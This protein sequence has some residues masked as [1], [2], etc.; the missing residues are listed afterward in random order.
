MPNS[1]SPV[2]SSNVNTVQTAPRQN[3]INTDENP[4]IPLVVNKIKNMLLENSHAFLQV[5]PA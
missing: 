5:P 3:S 1:N 4:E 2:N